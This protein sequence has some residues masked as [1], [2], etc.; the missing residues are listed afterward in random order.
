MANATS[1]S[2]PDRLSPAPRAKAA[3]SSAIRKP[4]LTAAERRENPSMS[5]YAYS[6]MT[7]EDLGAIYTYLRTLKPIVN[8]VKKHN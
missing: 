5:W 6:G 7:R 3:S 2:T 1:R 8:R 4:Q